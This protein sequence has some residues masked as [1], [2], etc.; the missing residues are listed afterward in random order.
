[1]NIYIYICRC[2]D[3]SCDQR[4]TAPT[5]SEL[6]VV[7]VDVS[8]GGISE[9]QQY[10]DRNELVYNGRVLYPPHSHEH[11]PCLACLPIILFMQ[12]TR[13]EGDFT[14]AHQASR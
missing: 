4:V 12:K 5:S 1:M 9:P 7:L 8:C 11:L 6:W 13:R 3:W 10:G 14:K 2:A